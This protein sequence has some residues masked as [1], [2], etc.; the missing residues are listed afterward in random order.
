MILLTEPIDTLDPCGAIPV[1]QV[2]ESLSLRRKV[3]KG[4]W[5]VEGRARASCQAD[6]GYAVPETVGTG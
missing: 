6:G 5:D 1:E 3:V 4:A 2:D